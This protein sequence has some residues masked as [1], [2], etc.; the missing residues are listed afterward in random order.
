MEVKLGVYP[1]PFTDMATFSFELE[2]TSVV[3]IV[4]YDLAGKVVKTVANGEFAQGANQ[5]QWNGTND[6]DAPVSAGVYFY[7]IEAGNSLI[8]NRIVL[9]R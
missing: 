7:R 9:T 5:V 8:T 2:E 6:G 3:K 1:N 4:I